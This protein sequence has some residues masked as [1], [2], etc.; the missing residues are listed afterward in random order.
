MSSCH[1]QTVEDMRN[2]SDDLLRRVLKYCGSEKPLYCG[3]SQTADHFLQA[4][5][6]FLFGTEALNDTLTLTFSWTLVKS[7]TAHLVVGFVG[8]IWILVTL[9]LACTRPAGYRPRTSPFWRETRAKTTFFRQ[10]LVMLSYCSVI[11]VVVGCVG[12][13][14][15]SVTANAGSLQCCSVGGEWEAVIGDDKGWHGFLNTDA[16]IRDLQTSYSGSVEDSSVIKT[17]ID[18]GWAALVEIQ[19]RLLCDSHVL[20]EFGSFIQILDRTTTL[21]RLARMATLATVYILIAAVHLPLLCIACA[22]KEVPPGRFACLSRLMLSLGILVGLSGGFLLISFVCH[23]FVVGWVS[24][25]GSVAERPSLFRQLPVV[26]QYLA[27]VVPNK[28]DQE[29]FINTCVGG[30]GRLLDSMG[31]QLSDTPDNERWL[32]DFDEALDCNDVVGAWLR[33]LSKFKEK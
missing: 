9:I 22:K 29:R 26:P 19:G 28:V 17:L 21:N 2:F 30:S 12:A 24:V 25:I 27:D 18:T 11:L 6:Y 23:A 4:F 33:P 20:T 16:D 1:I 13:V 32:A 10:R 31:L 8:F 3:L 15:V 5:Q 7:G 14:I